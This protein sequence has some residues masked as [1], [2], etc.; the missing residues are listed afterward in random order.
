MRN[1]IKKVISPQKAQILPK[2]STPTPKGAL[3]LLLFKISSIQKC[4]SV[5]HF[6]FIGIF[7]LIPPSGG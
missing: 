2:I 1:V 4:I 5:N 3:A 6:I 7:S